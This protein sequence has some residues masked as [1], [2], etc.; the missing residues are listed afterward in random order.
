MAIR[1]PSI[2]A[3]ISNAA[4]FV[5]E[6]AGAVAERV[7]VLPHL[8]GDS[9]AEAKE[10]LQQIIG[11]L[12]DA[13]KSL[14][15]NVHEIFEKR[16]IDAIEE[17]AIDIDPAKRENNCLFARLLHDVFQGRDGIEIPQDVC[18]YYSNGNGRPIG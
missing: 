10:D 17:C 16:G 6:T 14:F 4:D 11:K 13:R 7:E 12:N 9:L 2:E 1:K 3:L 18:E 5:K 15:G 8:A